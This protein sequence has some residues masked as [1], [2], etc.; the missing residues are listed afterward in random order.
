MNDRSNILLILTDQQRGDCIGLDPHAPELLQTP[1]CD[2][3]ARRGTH[4]H[5]G[6]SECPSCIPARRTIFSG[7]APAANGCVG[8][9][10]G[11]EWNP[12]H[13]LAGKLGQAG[14]QTEMIGKLH[15][16][17]RLKRYGFDHLQ[18]ADATRG[19][20]NDYTDWLVKQ[21]GH[22]AL[23][24]GMAHGVSSNGW[25]GRPHHL[26]EEKMHSFWVV[27]RAM[28]F[29]RK[30][31][32][33]APYFLNISFIDPHPPLTPPAFYYNRYINRDIPP[34][35]VGD[36]TTGFDGPERGLERDAS[37]LCLPEQDMQCAR[38]AYYGM[39]N[40][41]DDQI[42][43]LLQFADLSNTFI[44]FASDH[45]EML[46]DH[47]LFRKTFPY[48]ASARIPFFACAPHE[49]SLPSDITT[50]SPVGLQDIMPTLLDAAGVDVPDSCTGKSLLPIMRGETEAVRQILH[51]EHDGCYDYD[52]A[53][54][55]LTDG[56]EKYIW[57]TQTGQEQ[58]FDLDADPHERRDLASP[59][60]SAKQRVDAWRARLVDLLRDRPEGFT[61]G[62]Q[63]I[64]GRPHE[65]ALP[66]Y[67][68]G[69]SSYPFL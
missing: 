51:G 11:I 17:P 61:D 40:F 69:T 59:S 47:H 63:L 15:L 58:L 13:T 43:R 20:P 22:T 28:E 46:G 33:S 55:F 8:F 52:D 9:R 66:G 5:H 4:F 68:P 48:E 57:Y 38:A 27:D 31:D 6:Y 25:I 34:P 53:N 35:V 7:M 37:R 44:L 64:T 60:S 3:I 36:W 1:N 18:Q 24:P 26:P 56:H 65:P 45:G 49:W 14:Y 19:E 32:P 41:I 54:H 67:E 10:D 23:H 62:E 16:Y 2:A 42:G 30:R 12:P 39:V 50:A 21:H 29:L